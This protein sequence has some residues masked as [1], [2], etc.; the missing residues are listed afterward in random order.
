MGLPIRDELPNRSDPQDHLD[1]LTMVVR[2]TPHPAQGEEAVTGGYVCEWDEFDVSLLEAARL[3]TAVAWDE[4]RGYFAP[5]AARQSFEQFSWGADGSG[6]TFLI[7]LASGVSSDLVVAGMAYAV[8]KIRGSKTRA[9]EG[10]PLGLESAK[11]S[12]LH[13]VESVF[14]ES[15]ADLTVAEATQAGGTVQVRVTGR[16]GA[17][18]ATVATL[19]TGDPFVHVVRDGS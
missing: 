9:R 2:Q 3:S 18:S 16:H 10:G 15:Y 4:E 19:D 5:F 7:D 13:A 1:R 6:V 12:S 8:G 11:E 17:Y 14:G